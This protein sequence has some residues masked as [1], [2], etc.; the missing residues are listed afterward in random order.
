MTASTVV[1]PLFLQLLAD[2][3]GGPG[4]LLFGSDLAAASGDTG[5]DADAAA[6]QLAALPA[7]QLGALAARWP[8]FYRA[9]PAA[10]PAAPLLEA[11]G[12]A[13]WKPL[14]E[15]ALHRADAVF[16]TQLPSAHAGFRL[17]GLQI[18]TFW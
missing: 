12:Q 8:C 10:A 4:A 3:D 1:P 9:A 15:A 6:A 17:N 16:D 5:A 13:G 14:D 7:E 2:R 11:L 18:S